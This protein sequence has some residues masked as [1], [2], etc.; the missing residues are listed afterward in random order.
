MAQA[1]ISTPS[2]VTSAIETT[3]PLPSL[4]AGLFVSRAGN[5]VGKKKEPLGVFL[6]APTLAWCPRQELNLWPIA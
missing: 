2:P 6:K 4:E 5:G 1:A 3:R